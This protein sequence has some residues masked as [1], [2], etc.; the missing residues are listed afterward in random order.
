[1]PQVLLAGG[2]TGGHIYPNVAVA[3]RL[4]ARGFEDAVHFLVSDRPGDARIVEQLGYPATAIQVRPLPAPSRSWKL[5]GFLLAWRR[6]V[7]ATARLLVEIDVSAVVATGGFVSGPAVVAAHR[8]GIPVALVNLD[9]VPGVANRYLARCADVVFST[10]TTSRLPEATPIGLPLRRT[11]TALVPRAEA[12]RLLGLDP[13][14]RTLFIT[15]ATH[16][17]RSMI[18]AVRRLVTDPAMQASLRDW[19]V[20]HQC[21]TH[22]P[23]ELHAHYGAMGIPAKVVAYLDDMGIAWA[24]ADVAIARAGAGTVAEAW[25]N[26]VPTIFLPNPHHPHQRLGFNTRPLVDAGGAL[27]VNDQLDGGR[28]ATHLGKVLTDLLQDPQRRATMREALARTKPTDGSE[29]LADWVQRQPFPH[30]GCEPR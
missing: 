3:E 23:A 26:A 6:S 5:P 22:D 7:T 25:A 9:A 20:L 1:M 10:Y 30:E 12:R 18:D 17:A 15:G 16:G 2:G 8:A 13:D 4:G 29:V 24:A 27:T 14:L 11:A 19:Q 21:G 28:T